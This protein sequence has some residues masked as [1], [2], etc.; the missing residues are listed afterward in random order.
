M[1]GAGKMKVGQAETLGNS[2]EGLNGDQVI[3]EKRT[4]RVVSCRKTSD[5]RRRGAGTGVYIKVLF[6]TE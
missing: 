6:K 5:D 3:T 1:T 4:G 2:Q